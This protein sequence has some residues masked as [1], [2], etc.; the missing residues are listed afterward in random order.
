MT[1]INPHDVRDAVDATWIDW[2]DQQRGR[3]SP[4][5]MAECDCSTPAVCE[6]IGLCAAAEAADTRRAREFERGRQPGITWRERAE[7]VAI[8]MVVAAIVL[9]MLIFAGR[10][11][12]HYEA[13][14]RDA[15]AALTGQENNR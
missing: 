15:A 3:L 12:H 6:S 4:Q 7:D 1:R 14:V 2:P 11:A 9:G 5:T 10:A 8:L 13:G